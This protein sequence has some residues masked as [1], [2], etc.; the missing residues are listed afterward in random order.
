VKDGVRIPHAEIDLAW[1][2]YAVLLIYQL[3]VYFARI[4]GNF[5]DNMKEN[6]QRVDHAALNAN[7][8]TIIILNIT[9]F[10][11]NAPWLVALV[12]FAMLAG[13]I[14]KMP[15]F[16]LIYRYLFRPT[17]LM[18]P[19]I[20]LDNPEPHRFAQGFGGVVMLAA[21]IALFAG[22][23]PFGWALVWLVTALAALNAFGGFCVGCFIY[24]WLSRLR[25]PGF[26]KNPPDGIIPGMRPKESAGNES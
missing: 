24:Y 14:L 8:I 22:I 15:G 6:L 12:T 3:L 21:T 2:S 11:L 4:I 17:G 19:H 7:Q 13:T 23:A 25:V 1:R 18:K 10:V 20:L 16:I 26:L 9:A 5:G